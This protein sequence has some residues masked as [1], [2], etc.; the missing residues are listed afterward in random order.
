MVWALE[1]V[2]GVFIATLISLEVG[3]RLGQRDA[4]RAPLAHEGVSAIEAS[5]FAILSLLLG[6]SFAG[7]QSRLES[8]RT[9]ILQEANS[10]S[11]AYARVDLLPN[12]AQP[13][14]RQQYA[15]MLRARLQAYEH[16]NDSVV[17]QT[18][19][20]LVAEAQQDIWTLS[21]RAVASGPNQVAPLVLSSVNQ[22]MDASAARSVTFQTFLPSLI[23]VLLVTGALMSGLLAGYAMVRRGRRSWFHFAVYAGL[24]ALT[25]YVVLDLDHPQFGFINISPAYQ[26]LMELQSTI[27]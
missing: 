6:F 11:S 22:M 19:F 7:A 2:C 10:I 14:I 3:F 8:K 25:F 9:L 15:R 24:I 13:A 12:E 23:V 17:A 20:R 5:A 26:Q 21:V 27:K 1:V 18:D 16:R 4:Q